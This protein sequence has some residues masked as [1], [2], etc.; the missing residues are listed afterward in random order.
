MWSRRCDGGGRQ[1]HHMAKNSIVERSARGAACL[2]L[3]P[4][5]TVEAA[6]LP[7]PHSSS[8][9]PF[10]MNKIWFGSTYFVSR[11]LSVPL[12]RNVSSDPLELTIGK[13]VIHRLA[14]VPYDL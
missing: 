13:T 8:N 12:T 5:R 14:F 11:C 2:L 10:F 7:S 3:P 6:L 9:C 1:G 4:C